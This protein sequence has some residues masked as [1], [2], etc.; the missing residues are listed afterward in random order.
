M[1]WTRVGRLECP[2][3]GCRFLESMAVAHHVVDVLVTDC[4]VTR[5][6][7]TEKA[8]AAPREGRR[9]IGAGSS[10][11][12]ADLMSLW[13][14]PR[15]A[16]RQQ[17]ARFDVQQVGQLLEHC[18]VDGPYLG[19]LEATHRG[20]ADPNPSRELGLGETEGLSQLTEA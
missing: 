17:K 3:P 11:T 14:G 15:R 6:P 13:R 16:P 20:P 19:I 12:G 7:R 8:N 10:L 18:Q 9:P 5:K 1:L 4:Q 2:K